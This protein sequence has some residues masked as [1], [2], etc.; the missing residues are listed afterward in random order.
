MPLTQRITFKTV[1]KK[2]NQVQVP[3]LFRWQYK[4]EPSEILKIT[5][6]VEGALGVKE[7]FLGKMHK[8]GRIVIPKMQLALLR[9]KEPSLEGYALEVTLEPT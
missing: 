9:G 5:V 1:L 8:D 7:N 4:M 6:R 3:K 2:K